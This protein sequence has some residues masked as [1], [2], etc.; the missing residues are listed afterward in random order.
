MLTELLVVLWISAYFVSQ[1]AGLQKFSQLEPIYVDGKKSSVKAI[2]DISEHCP[3]LQ[4]KS[5]NH[6]RNFLLNPRKPSTKFPEQSNEVGLQS[7]SEEDLFPQKCDKKFCTPEALN[8][9]E[10]QP[11][12]SHEFFSP[13]LAGLSHEGSSSSQAGHSSQLYTDEDYSPFEY[14]KFFDRKHLAEIYPKIFSTKAKQTET[15]QNQH[16]SST[17]IEEGNKKNLGPD[18]TK[19]FAPHSALL[20]STKD[21]LEINQIGQLKENFPDNSMHSKSSDLW[22]IE[23][24]Y[25]E[26]D[27]KLLEEMLNSQDNQNL[28]EEKVDSQKDQNLF[29][30]SIN[31]QKKQDDEEFQF[32]SPFHNQ[33]SLKEP[34]GICSSESSRSSTLNTLKYDKKIDSSR[35]PVKKKRKISKI[36]IESEPVKAKAEHTNQVLKHKKEELVRILRNSFTIKPKKNGEPYEFD[37]FPKIKWSNKTPEQESIFQ[38]YLDIKILHFLEDVNWEENTNIFQDEISNFSQKPSSVAKALSKRTQLRTFGY[39]QYIKWEGS[40]FLMNQ[41]SELVLDF[42][43]LKHVNFP[44][45]SLDRIQDVSTVGATFI[46]IISK[47]FFKHPRSEEFGNNQKI[48]DYAESI[49]RICFSDKK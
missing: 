26:D 36:S 5:E 31:S 35:N 41:I 32:S 30:Y 28:P 14:S 27:Q 25:N 15:Q 49:W 7:Y 3:A 19:L 10:N 16:S 2:S 6:N 13:S 21:N 8:H 38:K 40:E 39:T 17:N 34:H 33:D 20:Y 12:K 1:I 43:N 4:K 45:G 44:G 46:K 22:K 48:F 42:K 37:I 18:L 23:I 24:N 9:R 29:G 47:V 11:V